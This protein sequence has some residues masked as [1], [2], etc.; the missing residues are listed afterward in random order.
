MLLNQH[1][2]R[3]INSIYVKITFLVLSSKPYQVITLSHNNMDIFVQ[4]VLT[5][6]A[7]GKQYMK[8]STWAFD[9]AHQMGYFFSP[10][11]EKV[12]IDLLTYVLDT[13][14]TDTE[15]KFNIREDNKPNKLFSSIYLH[16][17]YFVHV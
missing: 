2:K 16:H 12:I 4:A 10:S 14:D 7:V 3:I 15:N 17:C 5:L 9:K 8:N 1:S 13:H 11:T 6:L